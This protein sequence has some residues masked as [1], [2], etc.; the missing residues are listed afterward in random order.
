M[1]ADSGI[2]EDQL[3][4]VRAFHM[5]AALGEGDAARS[6]FGTQ[7]AVP[8]A[9]PDR[10]QQPR[11]DITKIKQQLDKTAAFLRGPPEREITRRAEIV[12]ATAVGRA[13]AA[14]PAAIHALQALGNAEDGTSAILASG[15][16]DHD[17]DPFIEVWPM[18]IY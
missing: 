11:K 15:A 18:T 3:G 5:R 4:A 14:N 8:A 1:P 12:A 2:L 13:G 9:P 7:I 16:Q 6:A 17:P 10:I